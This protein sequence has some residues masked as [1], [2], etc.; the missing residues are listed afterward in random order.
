[1][2]DLHTQRYA[3]TISAAPPLVIAHGLFGQG[4]N[5]NSLAKRFSER[6]DVIVADMRNH[7]DSPWSDVMSYDAMADDLA[8]V[9][10]REA[11]GHASILGHSMGGKAV[12]ALLAKAPNG[13]AAAIVAD[14]A[15]VAYSHSHA[16]FA[17]AMLSVDLAAA[18]TR[19]AVDTALK[20]SIP[21][22]GTRAFL[23][24]NLKSGADGLTW[25]ANIA[26]LREQMADIVGWPETFALAQT[27]VPILGLRGAAS[28]Y[29]I[30]AAGDAFR[31]FAPSA[32]LRN[33]ADAGHWLHAE[34]PDVFFHE[35]EGFLASRDL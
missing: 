9:I 34:A 17:D 3:A 26:V 31:A 12:M 13:I 5:F 23:L 22:R 4:R 25:R 20:V 10:R 1:M 30:G 16:S 29:M 21:D 18:K 14:I 8:S 35:V 32:E 7:G 11:G 15:P 28:E 24:Q 6:R 27:E 33:V 2:L 19:G